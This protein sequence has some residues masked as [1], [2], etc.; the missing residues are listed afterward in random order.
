MSAQKLNGS[1]VLKG[2]S[3][4]AL[5]CPPGRGEAP[6]SLCS[7]VA[8]AG[9]NLPYVTVTYHGEGR[10]IT[11]AVETRHESEVRSLLGTAFGDIVCSCGSC[12]V[13]SLFPHQSDPGIP[14]ALFSSFGRAGLAVQGMANSP[15]ALSLLLREE[16]LEPVSR[17]LF[18]AFT[19]RG[20]STPDEWKAAQEGKEALYKEVVASYQEKRPKVYG[21]TCLTDQQ[22]VCAVLDD[23]SLS[24]AA[25]VMSEAARRGLRL[26]L[27]ASAP[28]RSNGPF[29]LT[30]CLPRAPAGEPLD[31][32]PSPLPESPGRPAEPAAV[33]S[34]NGPHFGDRYGITSELLA[35]L[36]RGGVPLLALN[37]TVASITGA[38]PARDLDAALEA[39]QGCFEV[40]SIFR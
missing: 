35:A 39:I 19:F 8:G 25:P 33:F 7:A 15:S 34:M 6:L 18:D 28:V 26:S 20:C 27:I 1:K 3:A 40:P 5:S 2:L 17:V 24:P 13:L 30:Y 11:L 31:L 10:L 23:P 16:E 32:L 36:G 38:V 4:F 22:I 37:C 29:H 9:I 21:V 12:A 14:A